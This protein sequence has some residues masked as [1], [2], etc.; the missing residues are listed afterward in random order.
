MP[1]RPKGKRKG[2]NDLKN[3]TLKE[4]VEEI[5]RLKKEDPEFN[6]EINEFIREHT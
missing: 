5:K 2:R 1:R 6:K 3:L 4:L